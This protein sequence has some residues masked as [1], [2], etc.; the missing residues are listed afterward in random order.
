[1]SIQRW[2]SRNI[3]NL[4]CLRISSNI[5]RLSIY[6]WGL[7]YQKFH[8]SHS[9]ANFWT[10]NLLLNQRPTPST[11]NWLDNWFYITFSI[12]L[13][14]MYDL[15]QHKWLMADKK[16]ITY[17]N[18][19]SLFSIRANPTRERQTLAIWFLNN[20]LT[21]GAVTIFYAVFV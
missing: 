12:A 8:A 10:K 17:F 18:I 3:S 6:R 20:S 4:F 16:L 7:I 1:M 5:A 15:T 19:D 2:I 11:I 9:V 21:S 13:L 14:V